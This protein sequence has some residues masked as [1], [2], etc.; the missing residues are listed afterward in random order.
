[1]MSIFMSASIGWRRGSGEIG[2]RGGMMEARA[3]VGKVALVTGASS[4][5]GERFARLLAA[6]GAAVGV[7]ARRRD[8]LAALVGELAGAG[9]RA[10]SVALDVTEPSSIAN[11]VMAVE[12]A[13]GSIDILVNNA[14]VSR[15]V[16][17]TDVSEADYDAVM[18][19]NLKGAFLVAQ[20]VGRRM[21]ARG[22]GGKIV[23][24]ASVLGSAVIPMLSIYAMAKGGLIQMTRAMA[25]EWARHDIQVNAL[26]PGYIRTEINDRF[27]RSEAGQKLIARLLRRRVG[28][29]TDLDGA[30]LLLVGEASRFVTG[31]V[32]TVDDGQ[33]L[34]GL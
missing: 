28:E 22:S 15:E 29:P 10:V 27:F 11:G 7:A 9:S 32:V 21:I 24:I 30:L 34:R 1:M 5:L 25:L 12:D 18:D 3:L 20:A 16:W 4:G 19:T 17:I 2:T 26:A 31:T 14:G 8:R 6:H 23:N 33:S 13:L